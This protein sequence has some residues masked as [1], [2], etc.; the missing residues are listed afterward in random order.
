MSEYYQTCPQPKG[1]SR[2]T[3]KSRKA[4]VHRGN[5]T[6]VRAYV[7]ARERNLCRCCR[8]RPAESMHELRP[9]SLRGRVSKTNS[10]ALCGSGTTGCHGYC[11]SNQIRYAAGEY[12]AEGPVIFTPVTHP[13]AEWLRIMQHEQIESR[14]MRDMEE[15]I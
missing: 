13:A 14:P 3:L 8:F 2:K 10:V 7:F 12:G 5:V 1:P 6:E 9:K 4:R 11:Q 15:A